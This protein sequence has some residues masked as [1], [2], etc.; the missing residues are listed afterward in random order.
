[1]FD[2][3][4]LFSLPTQWGNFTGPNSTGPK[5]KKKNEQQQK[6]I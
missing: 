3:A 5:K 2:I 6:N 1:M 4:N